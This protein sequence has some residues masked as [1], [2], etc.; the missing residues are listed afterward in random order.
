M[1]FS[2]DFGFSVVGPDGEITEK[3]L[4]P[5]SS[6]FFAHFS[7]M[8]IMLSTF[9]DKHPRPES[10]NQ[11]QAVSADITGSPDYL[12]SILESLNHPD[13]SGLGNGQ[14]VLINGS[15]YCPTK[16]RILVFTGLF[17]HRDEIKMWRNTLRDKIPGV[18]EE[19]L[20]VG[21][22]LEP[23]DLLIFARFPLG[24]Y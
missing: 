3:F 14:I 18:S 8:R 4:K 17:A 10:F 19:S 2:N 11:A 9:L 5:G 12:L 20:R 15:L 23:M 6:E 1:H 13:I 21:Y 7:N 22:I 16:I 24:G